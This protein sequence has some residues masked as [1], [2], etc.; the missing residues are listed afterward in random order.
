MTRIQEVRDDA[1][2]RPR[3]RAFAS[4]APVAVPLAAAAAVLALAVA[5]CIVFSLP[6]GDDLAIYVAAVLAAAVIAHRT[7]LS[8]IAGLA[9]ALIRPYALGERVRLRSPAH[10]GVVDAEVVRIGA[11]NTTL[12]TENGLFVVANHLLLKGAP[13]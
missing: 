4:P 10:G 13:D 5:G 6:L 11:A 7:V 2:A 12:A 8:L 3:E 9:L 1:R